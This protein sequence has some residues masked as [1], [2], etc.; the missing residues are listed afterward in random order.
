MV[1]A[2]KN[3]VSNQWHENGCRVIML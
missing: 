1:M 3:H 2:A